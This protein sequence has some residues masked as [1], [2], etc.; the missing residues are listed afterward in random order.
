VSTFL[1][2]RGSRLTRA[3]YTDKREHADA[4]EERREVEIQGT[5]VTEEVRI[6]PPCVRVTDSEG[7]ESQNLVSGRLSHYREC[8]LHSLFPQCPLTTD[9]PLLCILI[10][11]VDLY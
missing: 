5:P 8:L 4:R 11:L 6:Q 3:G 10:P 2:P 1:A 9:I 7:A